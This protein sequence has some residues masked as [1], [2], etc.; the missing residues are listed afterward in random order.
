[1]VI[2]ETYAAPFICADVKTF[3]VMLPYAEQAQL[4]LS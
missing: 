2:K 1:M 4:L 3:F